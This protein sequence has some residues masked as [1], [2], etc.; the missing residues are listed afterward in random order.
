[1]FQRL[2]L[3]LTLCKLNAGRLGDVVSGSNEFGYDLT[4]VLHQ[5][6]SSNFWISPFCITSCFTLIYP[7][8][9]DSL[10]LCLTQGSRGLSP[11]LVSH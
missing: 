2:L 9:G 4:N 11:D 3:L 7:G 6:P 10:S 8:S 1:M 5:D